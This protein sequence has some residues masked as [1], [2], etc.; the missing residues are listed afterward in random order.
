MRIS[1]FDFA[2]NLIAMRQTIAPPVAEPAAQP[3]L[4]KTIAKNRS[5]L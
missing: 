1:S 4:P 5:F 3:F 2:L